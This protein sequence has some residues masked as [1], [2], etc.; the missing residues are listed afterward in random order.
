MRMKIVSTGWAFS[1]K[2]RAELVKA[3]SIKLPEAVNGVACGEGWFGVCRG[4]AVLENEPNKPMK[5]CRGT[6]GFWVQGAAVEVLR[7]VYLWSDRYFHRELL[8]RE[9]WRIGRSM[10]A[11]QR[12]RKPHCGTEVS[13]RLRQNLTPG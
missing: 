12:N 4:R 10:A 7:A 13:V 6:A 8:R 3:F 11:E 1:E 9:L 2:L 5:M